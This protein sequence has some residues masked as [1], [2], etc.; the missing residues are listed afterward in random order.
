MS[1][2]DT[3][4]DSSPESKPVETRSGR[5]GYTPVPSDIGLMPSTPDAVSDVFGMILSLGAV[6]PIWQF[7][8][9]FCYRGFWQDDRTP[10]ATSTPAVPQEV[11]ITI[12]TGKSLAYDLTLQIEL[13]L[14]SFVTNGRCNKIGEPSINFSLAYLH[15]GSSLPGISHPILWK[16]SPGKNR[17]AIIS[18]CHSEERTLQELHFSNLDGE[19][20]PPSAIE[21]CQ[22]AIGV[23][24]ILD[25]IHSRKVRH[26]NLR[27]E[28][29]NIWKVDGEYNIC[30]RDFTESA[31]LLDRDTPPPGSPD[32]EFDESDFLS[33]TPCPWYLPPE[34]LPG[35]SDPGKPLDKINSQWI[36][37]RTSTP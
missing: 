35:S 9:L 24:Q 36:I 32:N 17:F 11:I 19:Y 26:G 3:E 4:D 30:I 33:V 28:V 12:A 29:I 14:E 31:L 25:S 8:S 7:N 27:P 37:V 2:T 21:V 5:F 1:G 22:I 6:Q 20:R 15:T 23:V 13:R 10:A 34:L 16:S 18:R